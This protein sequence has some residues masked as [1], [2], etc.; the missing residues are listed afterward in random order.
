MR[1][2]GWPKWG[3]AWVSRTCICPSLARVGWFLRR[4]TPGW[5]TVGTRVAIALTWEAAAAFFVLEDALA[6]AFTFALALAGFLSV[7]LAMMHSLLRWGVAKVEVRRSA[8]PVQSICAIGSDTTD[9]DQNGISSSSPSGSIGGR[10]GAG[11]PGGGKPR[12]GPLLGPRRAGASRAGASR[13]DD[14]PS[15][16]P[17]PA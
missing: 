9:P 8:R 14:S 17:P 2:P 1:S 6:L 13:A 10:A 11:R 15:D 4:S 7:I 3:T 5:R 12:A 16:I